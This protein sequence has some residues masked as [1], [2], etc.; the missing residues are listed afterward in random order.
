[1]KTSYKGLCLI[2]GY[3]KFKPVSYLCPAGYPT[4]GYGHRILPGEKFG[5]ITEIEAEELLKKDVEIAEKAIEKLIKAEINQEI[6]DALVSFIF[7]VGET[8]FRNSTLLKLLRSGDY[9][10]TIME[11]SNW[12]FAGGKILKGLVKR[13]AEEALFFTI[14]AFKLGKI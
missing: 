5:K 8:N 1:M 2:I 3:E 10:G 14:G 12:I 9:Y 6:F 4:I 7:N 13:R 11:F